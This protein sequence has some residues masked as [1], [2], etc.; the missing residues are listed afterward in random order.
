MG[1]KR[2]RISASSLIEMC[3]NDGDIVSFKCVTSGSI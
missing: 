1:L 3:I 2:L